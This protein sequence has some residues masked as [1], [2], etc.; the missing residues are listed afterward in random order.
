M[1]RAYDGPALDG[2]TQYST[3]RPRQP[4]EPDGETVY[5]TAPNRRV[6]R[7]SSS[8]NTGRHPARRRWEID[9]RGLGSGLRDS[10]TERVVSRTKICE[11]D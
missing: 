1:R 3:E 7:R 8:S 9:V 10:S 5:A 4:D 6:K 11:S 2:R